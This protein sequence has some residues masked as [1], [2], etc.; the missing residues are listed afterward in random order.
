MLWFDLKDKVPPTGVQ[1]HVSI[2]GN[3][4]V[5]CVDEKGM[6]I[7]A[8]FT[9]SGIHTQTVHWANIESPKAAKKIITN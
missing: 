2:G 5:G 9:P 7:L 8:G 1:V 6:L 3:F 4:Y